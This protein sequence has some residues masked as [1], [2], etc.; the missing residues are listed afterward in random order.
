MSIFTILFV[1]LL[2]A[3]IM[4]WGVFHVAGAMIHLLLIVALI[5]L[6][7]HFVRGARAV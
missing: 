5:S 4:G 6:I 2:I 3:W 7:L 1:I